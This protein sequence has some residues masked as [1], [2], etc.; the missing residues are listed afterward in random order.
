MYRNNTHIP[1]A[2]SFTAINQ[3]SSPQAPLILHTQPR[4]AKV[5]SVSKFGRRRNPTVASYLG[6]GD[7]EEPAHLVNYAPTL[8][9][10]PPPPQSTRKRRSSRNGERAASR[11][12]PTT[13]IETSSNQRSTSDTIRV[14]DVPIAAQKLYDSSGEHLPTPAATTSCAELR[15]SQHRQVLRSAVASTER[16][17]ASEIKSTDIY[18]LDALFDDDDDDDSFGQLCL[19]F[20]INTHNAGSSIPATH[21]SERLGSP[22]KQPDD[23][24]FDDDLMDDDLL[25]LTTDSANNPNSPLL[26]SSS[27]LKLDVLGGPARHEQALESAVD[28]EAT[29]NEA[30]RSPSGATKKFV[31]PVTLTSRMLAATGDEA[32][33]PIVRPPFPTAVRD[34]SPVIGMSSNAVLRC[35]FRIGEAIS[36]SCHAAKADEH[37]LIELY[38]RILKSERDELQQ[39]FTFCDLFHAKPPYI[40]ATYAA[41]IWRTSQLFEYDSTRLMQQGRIC[42]CIGTMKRNGKEWVM[43]VLNIW[44]ATWE[45]VQ[46]VEGIV[47]S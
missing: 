7:I 8:I 46:W 15:Q 40:Q 21:A 10:R 28:P 27:P 2:S 37:I 6:L 3:G 9:E 42:R 45:D 25:D 16:S 34:R 17:T 14:T 23:E 41:A 35:C 11:K 29:L 22:Q 1:S 30:S 12:K 20:D 19:N 44:E 26:W 5:T 32:R 39:R 43:T 4:P 18:D 31:S 38:A 24:N 47:N 36:Q 13:R 33:K